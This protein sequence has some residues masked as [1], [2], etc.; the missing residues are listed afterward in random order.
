MH[1]HVQVECIDSSIV[2]GVQGNVELFVYRAQ[3]NPTTLECIRHTVSPSRPQSDSEAVAVYPWEEILERC[4]EECV[5]HG[6]SNDTF[7]KGFKT[8]NV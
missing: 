4:S 1:V 5:H 3:P 7:L 6:S 8:N 2:S